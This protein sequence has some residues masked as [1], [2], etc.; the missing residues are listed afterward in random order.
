MHFK[1]TKKEGKKFS[2]KSGDFNQIHLNELDGYNSIYGQIICHGCLV[3][4]KTIKLKEIKKKINNLYSDFIIRINFN[5]YFS[6]NDKINLIN[7]KNYK[8]TQNNIECAS[9]FIEKIKNKNLSKL[10][11]KN[12]IKIIEKILCNIS[13]HVGMINPGKNSILSEIEI[14]YDSN[15][16]YEKKLS[17]ISK[18]INKRFPIIYN[19]LKFQNFTAKFNSIIR[20]I[21]LKKKDKI[22]SKILDKVMSLKR[23]IIIIGGSQGVGRDL[24]NLVKINKKI[25][26]ISTFYKN[27]IFS[28]GNIIAK[29][30]DLNRNINKV[31]M[32]VKKYSPANIYYFAS[33]KIYFDNYLAKNHKKNYEKFFINFPTKILRMNY[34]KN[35]YFFYPSTK[36]ISI[37]KKSVYAKIKKK[38]ENKISNLCKKLSIKYKILRLGAINSRQTISLMG[39]T[40][41][42]LNRYLKDN[43]NIID[44]FL[45]LNLKKN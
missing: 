19:E 3:F 44:D 21:L 20:P 31:K 17:I 43:R 28:H 25:K 4:L 5:N 2:I 41:P 22:N 7:K 16:K 12:V 40:A 34:K 14:C 24:L 8:L 39:D 13:K 30:I 11:K 18:K 9:F 15:N 29:K 10:G 1:I 45:L 23:N 38:A 33:N 6:Y 37:N 36:Y 26:I 42:S 27:K 35:I 32:L